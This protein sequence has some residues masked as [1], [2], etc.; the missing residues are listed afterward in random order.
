MSV[1]L[2]TKERAECHTH[3]FLG[4]WVFDRFVAFWAGDGFGRR[5]DF[6]GTA[7]TSTEM[8]V[9][10]AHGDSEAL[11][12]ASGTGAETSLGAGLAAG[13]GPAADGVDTIA[14]LVGGGLRER[15]AAAG[16][17]QVV[18]DDAV[19]LAGAVAPRA[20]QAVELLA[21]CG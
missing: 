11:G 9:S 14:D 6:L 3:T 20:D 1:A 16:P 7:V 15:R 19:R 4:M 5:P 21:E 18:V 12:Q 2:C 13:D 17:A 10:G 8:L